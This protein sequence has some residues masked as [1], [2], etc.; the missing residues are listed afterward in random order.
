MFSKN[1]N[2]FVVQPY[3]YFAYG[4]I[5]PS[6]LFSYFLLKLK[7]EYLQIFVNC[8][9]TKSSFQY[10]CKSSENPLSLLAKFFLLAHLY[11]FREAH[12]T[13]SVVDHHR[14]LSVQQLIELAHVGN[15]SDGTAI[16]T[17]SSL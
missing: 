14:S 5:K 15:L 9:V 16:A 3:L 6:F 7:L 17:T 11:S 2:Y 4:F 10:V 8:F 12:Q 13:S 1:L